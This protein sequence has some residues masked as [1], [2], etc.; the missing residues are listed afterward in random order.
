MDDDGFQAYG[1]LLV[2]LGGVHI[3][4]SGQCVR[5]GHFGSWGDLPLQVKVLEE[6]G[7][8]GLLSG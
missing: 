7:S 8:S 4:T 5:R 6:E 2:I 3:V 1:C